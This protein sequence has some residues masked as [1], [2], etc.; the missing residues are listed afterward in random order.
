MQL[1]KVHIY[2]LIIRNPKIVVILS[3]CRD[4]NNVTIYKKAIINK[5]VWTAEE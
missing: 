5:V 2:F 4:T 1:M 3:F